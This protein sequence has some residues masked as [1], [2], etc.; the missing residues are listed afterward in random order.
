MESDRIP[1]NEIPGPPIGNARLF[2]PAS[3]GARFAALIIDYIVMSFPTMVAG[4]FGSTGLTLVVSVLT[5]VA[6]KP[7]MES[8]LGLT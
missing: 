8:Q 1:P 7:I 4:L 6:Y 3:F 2:T 5:V